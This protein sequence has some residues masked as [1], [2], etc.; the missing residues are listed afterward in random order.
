LKF[1]PLFRVN[2]LYWGAILRGEERFREEGEMA[3]KNREEGERTQK[4]RETGE[5]A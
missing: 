2:F 3:P 4:K 1:Y 5:P